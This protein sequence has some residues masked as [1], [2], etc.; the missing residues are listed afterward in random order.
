MTKIAEF[1]LNKTNS[2]IFNIIAML[3]FITGLQLIA[4]TPYKLFV[5][6]K[7]HMLLSLFIPLIIV[8]IHEGMHALAYKM[9]GAKLKLGYKHFSL[10]LIDTSGNLF[11]HRQIAII[12][13]FP[14]LCMSLLLLVAAGIFRN[15]I[16]F[17]LLSLL[18]NLAGSTGDILLSVYIILIGR[19]CWVKDEYNGFS[20]YKT[21]TPRSS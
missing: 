13:L 5:L 20:I 8:F 18:I 17:I 7:S 3:I 19:N 4:F 1:K 15:Y 16:S 6:V 21:K 11:T 10:Y 2:F 12:M 9:F 14:V